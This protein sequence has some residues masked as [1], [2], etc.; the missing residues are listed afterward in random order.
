[1]DS[2]LDRKS[3]EKNT[4][5]QENIIRRVSCNL[6]MCFI[7]TSIYYKYIINVLQISFFQIVAIIYFN[8]NDTKHKRNA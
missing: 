3:G 8:T 1:M 7:Y 5:E 2:Y 6:Y 4:S